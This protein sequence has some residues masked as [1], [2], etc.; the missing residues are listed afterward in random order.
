M[1]PRTCWLWISVVWLAGTNSH[2]ETIKWFGYCPTGSD[3]ITSAGSPMGGSFSFEL[4]VFKNAFVPSDSNTSQWAANW[5]AAQRVTY[6]AQN[7][8]F[9]GQFTVTNNTAP[10]TIGAAAYVWGFQ[11]GVAASEWILFRKSTWTWPAPNPTDPFGLDWD[12][13][14][15]TTVLGSIN[16][17]GS[18]FFMRSAAVTD[19]AS[20]TTT[21]QQ[22]Q[23]AELAGEPLNGANDDPDHDGT[24]NLM[25]YVFGTLP[26]QA[27]APPSTPVEIVTVTGQRY[28]QI[29]I[30]RRIDHPATLTVQ[31]SSNL[32]IWNSGPSSTLTVSNTPA[33]LVVRDLTP[34]SP[35]VPQR[36]IRLKAELV[37]P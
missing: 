13:A 33:A 25:E 34:L 36:F 12:A 37:T 9:T 28:L 21:W 11:G 15:A 7:K 3:N 22:W 35:G 10:F 2:A 27:G 19:G 18:P 17:G 24:L 4:G 1:A 20:P 6:N 32:A 16:A 30:P 26:K 31:V 14:T 5:V 8:V 23:A 29:T